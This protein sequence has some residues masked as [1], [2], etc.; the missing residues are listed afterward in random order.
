MPPDELRKSGLSLARGIQTRLS[1]ILASEFPTDAPQRLGEI[2]LGLVQALGSTISSNDD[3][4]VLKFA[5]GCLQEIGSHLRYIEGASS[6]RISA[7]IVTPIEMLIRQMEPHARVMVRVQSA[8]NYEIFNIIE[9]YKEMLGQLLGQTLGQILG[10]TS[11]LFVVAVPSIEHSNV[12]LH[13]I[14]CHEAGHRI[15][16][17]YLKSEDQQELIKHI[18]GLIGDD[19]TW[20]DP[21]IKSKG[22]L[23]EFEARQRIFKL[24][25][26][27][28]NCALQELIS[29]IVSYH[30]CGISALFAL[31]EFSSSSDVL[32]ALPDP[33]AGFY[34]PWRYRIRQLVNLAYSERLPDSIQ[35]ITGPQ[36]TKLI[37]ER[38]LR[39][40]ERLKATADDTTDVVKIEADP[41]LERAYRDIPKTMEKSLL[42]IQKDF[43][44]FKYANSKLE[45]ELSPLLERLAL[46][47]PPDLLSDKCPDIRSALV[48][49]WLYRTSRLKIPNNES[50]TWEPED[51]E[52]LNRLVLK[53]I[54][55]VQLVREFKK[56]G[57]QGR[58]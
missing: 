58:A 44:H 48:A 38:S 49:G 6:P 21:E 46:G 9:Y 42:L 1:E 16:E 56:Q 29:D 3:E 47:I 55:S 17:K 12:L 2:M 34:P 41:F 37:I 20:W 43:P 45:Q 51:D 10:S 25:H 50:L 52:I 13:S 23:W 19:L 39:R 33:R 22:P 30:L 36:P 15:A 54:E 26:Q 24:L 57:A 27:A 4:R 11:Q 28:R 53:A 32:D 18:N 31:D 35:R 7:S 14:L 40:L 8:Y 5:C